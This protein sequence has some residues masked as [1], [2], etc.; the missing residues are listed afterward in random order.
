MEHPYQALT[1]SLIREEIPG[2]KTFYFESDPARPLAY[3]AGQ[4]LTLVLNPGQ[5]ELRRSYSIISTP[6]LHEPLGIGVKRIEN[7]LFSRYL[8]DR[9]K[10]GDQVLTIGAGGLFTLPD[11]LEDYRQ[12]FFLAAGSGITPVLSLLKAVLYGHPQ[13]KAILI[14]S[15]HSPEQV[16]YKQELIHL[17]ATFTNRFKLEMLY[18]DAA[19][20]TRARLHKDLLLWFINNYASAASEQVLAYVCGPLN[21]MRMCIYGLRESSIPN[22]NIRKENFSTEKPPVLTMPPDQ[23]AHLVT[24]TWQQ[25][26]YQVRVQYPQTILQAA[27]KSGIPLPYSCEAGRCGN[28]L[29]R[30]RSGQV[31]LAY[32]EVLT[33]KELAQ[34]LTLTC[35]AYPVGGDVVLEI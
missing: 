6:V 4:Y 7:G 29:A 11:H 25:A 1:I 32:N 2:F 28:C 8:I 27:R 23:E 19:D 17:A 35:M 34:G 5:Q 13:L 12:V 20:L 30:C 31:W 14:Y 21:Y 26:S 18:S 24:L 10:T 15:N 3:Q 22:D 9:A 33:D 16:I